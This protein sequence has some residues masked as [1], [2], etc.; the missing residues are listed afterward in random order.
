MKTFSPREI[1]YVEW[2]NRATRFY[3]A[4]RRLHSSDL[5]APA[6][7]CASIALEL[8]LKATLVYWDKSFAPQAT[9]HDMAKLGR[10][11]SNKVPNGAG[12]TVPEYF[13][14]EQRYLVVSRY[15]NSG[16][17]LGIPATFVYDLD[18]TFCCL[19]RL[20]PFQHNTELKRVLAGRDRRAL[21]ILRNRSIRGLRASL[22]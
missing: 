5:H 2:Q 13:Y 1:S 4:A 17:G 19:V 9:G 15:P 16:K 10:I 22:R 18:W 3:L 6:A 7:Y 11:L 8:L 12:F 21:D 20:V 14:T